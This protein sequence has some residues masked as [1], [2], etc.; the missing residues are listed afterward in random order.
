MQ[1]MQLI[2]FKYNNY[3]FKRW[4]TARWVVFVFADI[5]AFWIGLV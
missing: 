4:L 3:K 2:M 1:L 5:T